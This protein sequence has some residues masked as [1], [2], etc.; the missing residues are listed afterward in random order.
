[1]M[2]DIP[3]NCIF[4]EESCKSIDYR[5]KSG[6]RADDYASIPCEHYDECKKRST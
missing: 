6:N 3:P 4:D 5:S 1:M 2:S